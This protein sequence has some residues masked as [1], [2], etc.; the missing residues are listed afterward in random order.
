MSSS[1]R[2]EAIAERSELV[3]DALEAAREAHAGQIRN[4]SGGMPYI[5][6]PIT[7]AELLAA[8]GLP[9]EVLAAALLHDVV[10]ESDAELGEIRARFGERVGT[11]VGALTDPE[12]IQPYERRKDA[13][14]AIVAQAGPDALAIYAADKLANLRALRRVYASEGEAVGEELK[15]PLEV[16]VAVW[17]ADI[18]MLAREAPSLPFLGELEAQLAGLRADRAAAARAP[19]P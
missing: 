17:G 1:P 11:L 18:S 6:H 12:E 8:Q 9:E 13:H 19:A 5:E 4:G 7:V 14:R 2:I 16:K 10:E 15:A 3:R